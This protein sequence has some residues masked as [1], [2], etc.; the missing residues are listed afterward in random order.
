MP[1]V[2]A[3]VWRGEW[4]VVLGVGVTQCRERGEA[5]VGLGRGADGERV[6]VRVVEGRLLGASEAR[7]LRAS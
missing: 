1:E 2:E 6:A 4:W 3:G 7:Q 5:G